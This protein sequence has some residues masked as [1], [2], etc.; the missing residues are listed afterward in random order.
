MIRTVP[1]EPPYGWTLINELAVTPSA[2]AGRE[3]EARPGTALVIGRAV[4]RSAG[5]SSMTCAH[6]RSPA[7]RSDTRRVR[8]ASTSGQGSP[9]GQWYGDGVYQVVVLRPEAP[10]VGVKPP[11]AAAERA[12]RPGP[13]VPEGPA[14]P[15]VEPVVVPE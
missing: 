1:E 4:R 13:I 11:A 9:P 14:D 15:T 7:P 12:A 10:P 6:A 2:Q 5:A 3:A 8:R